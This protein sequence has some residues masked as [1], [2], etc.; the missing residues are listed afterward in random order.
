MVVE[1]IMQLFAYSIEV[2]FIT[3]RVTCYIL[4][5][6][7]LLVSAWLFIEILCKN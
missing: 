7:L 3:A 5:F 4:F 6:S 1:E 2:V